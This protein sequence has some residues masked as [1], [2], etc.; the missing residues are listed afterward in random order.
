MTAI[1]LLAFPRKSHRKA[2]ILP[3]PSRNLAELFGIMIGDGGINNP[4]QA[5]VSLNSVADAEYVV[6]VGELFRKLF[7]VT[8]V[9][10]K[11]KERNTAVVSLSSTTV[12]DFLV[13]NGLPRGDKLKSGLRIP[14]WILARDS[15]R[16][17]C[18]RG[19]M[20][21]DG[22]L[23]IHRHTVSGKQYRNIGLCFSSR[24]PQLLRQVAAIL[25]ECKITPHLNTKGTEIYLYQADAVTRYLQLFGTANSRISSVYSAWK[26][27]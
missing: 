13:S 7:G 24:S 1:R 9:V 2:V 10:R 27:G 6:Y 4:W 21:T 14:D 25:E 5:N 22:C 19:L 23:Y 8:A 3:R 17:A 18:V 11:R 26:D 16:N 12:V 20:D 15:W